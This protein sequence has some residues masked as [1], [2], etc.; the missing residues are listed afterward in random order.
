MCVNVS[1]VYVVSF[2]P[3]VC[4]ISFCFLF[5]VALTADVCGFF[6]LFTDYEKLQQGLLVIEEQPVDVHDALEASI[7]ALVEQVGAPQAPVI[8]LSIA[9]EVP[10]MV[11]A[12]AFRLRYVGTLISSHLSF[13][14]SFV[15]FFLLVVLV[16]LYVASYL[17]LLFPPR[18]FVV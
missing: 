8:A 3:Y 2:H 5:P 16:R 10:R 1:S 13:F 15:L 7:R 17:H 9:A 6:P 12:D 18:A 11:R 14:L 4:F